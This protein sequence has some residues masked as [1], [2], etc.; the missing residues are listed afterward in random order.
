MDDPKPRSNRDKAAS[1][2]ANALEIA[3]VNGIQ[4]TEPGCAYTF[5][6]TFQHL[7]WLDFES[8]VQAGRIRV[9]LYPLAFLDRLSNGTRYSTRAA[10]AIATVADRAPESLLAF[11]AALFLEQPAEGTE[12]LSDAR[13][14]ELAVR[15]GVPQEVAAAF[16]ERT[17]EPWIASVTSTAVESGVTATPTVKIDG[18]VFKDLYTPGAFKRAAETAKD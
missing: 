13:L 18:V 17:F 15:S 6:R 1:R 12:G 7:D 3:C 8:L 5:E 9:E 11:H 2:A 16:T 4:A 10:N 14:A